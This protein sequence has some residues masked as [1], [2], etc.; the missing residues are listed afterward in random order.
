MNGFSVKAKR[1]QQR[2]RRPPD[3]MQSKICLQRQFYLKPKMQFNSIFTERHTYHREKPKA[4]SKL[5]LKHRINFKPLIITKQNGSFWNNSNSMQNAI[6]NFIFT[7]FWYYKWDTII[8]VV[9][10]ATSLKRFISKANLLALGWMWL[11]QKRF[12][13]G[14]RRV[15]EVF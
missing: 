1:Q 10:E 8:L 3:D 11:N 5:C 6:T 9:C 14:T 13:N 12:C 4:P 15:I 2:R 7:P